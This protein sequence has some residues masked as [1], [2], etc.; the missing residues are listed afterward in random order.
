M[1]AK[2]IYL[3][4]DTGAK[5]TNTGLSAD[6]PVAT[7]SRAITLADQNGDVVHV[8][9]MIDISK[10]PSK[11]GNNNDITPDGKAV[12][13]TGGI[14]YNT[15]NVNGNNGIKLLGRDITLQGDD[16]ETD[17]F[18]AKGKTR[19]L[20]ID[21][22]A[23]ASTYNNLTFQNGNSYKDGNTA[24]SNDAGAGI[25]LRNATTRF[26]NC[27]FKDNISLCPDNDGAKKG[28]AVYYNNM[29]ES[30]TGVFVNCV[31]AGNQA[32]EGSAFHIVAAP[33]GLNIQNCHFSG[34]GNIEITDSKGGAI[35]IQP[36]EGKDVTVNVEKSI[37][38]GNVAQQFGGVACVT[39]RDNNASIGF[40]FQ[41]CLMH[42]N[43]SNSQG[44]VLRVISEFANSTT[45]VAFI[46]S[47]IYGNSTSIQGGVGLFDK[48]VGNA[49]LTVINSTITG[50]K[51][52]GENNVGHAGGFRVT[53]QSTR[54]V[55]MIYNS[56]IEGN[57]NEMS[58]SYNDFTFQGNKP[59]HFD[60]T[61]ANGNIFLANS[62]IGAL[63]RDNGLYDNANATDCIIDYSKG[64]VY[65]NSAALLAGLSTNPAF[66]LEQYNVIPL[67]ENAMAKDFADAQY[68]RSL[69]INTDQTGRIRHFVNDKCFAG[70][71]EADEVTIAELPELPSALITPDTTSALN[72]ALLTGNVY[73]LLGQ[74]IVKGA[75][76]NLR[77]GIYIVTNGYQSYKLW[78]R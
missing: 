35:F 64:M 41:D 13:T 29:E 52:T 55:K 47:T 44:G 74:R 65:G 53:D 50:N 62:F 51:T 3:S 39:D 68:L 69:N 73:N 70:A 9:G 12:Y 20:R 45:D 2:D 77:P 33:G 32:R 14:T 24:L 63:N 22:L 26:E 27:I 37:F 1:D 11:A 28:G 18:D 16:S 66:Y 42:N 48:V 75:N 38:D 25:Y 23:T 15:W 71:V 36:I 21:G 76:Q 6:A 56:I 57:Y 58:G 30:K 7:L 4:S 8:S 5:D 61:D 40:I 78:V 17:G 67:V 19:V 54:L 10:E 31:F 72:E 46:N 59:E 49:S 60:L 34:N 43:R